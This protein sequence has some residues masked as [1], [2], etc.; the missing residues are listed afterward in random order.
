MKIGFGKIRAAVF[1]FC[2]FIINCIFVMTLLAFLQQQQQQQ[3]LYVLLD[4]IIASCVNSVF[5]PRLCNS[6]EIL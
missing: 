4:Q 6:G 2:S 3:L 1:T 5:C